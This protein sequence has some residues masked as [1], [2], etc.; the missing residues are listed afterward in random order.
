[1]ITGAGITTITSPNTNVAVG[2]SLSFGSNNNNGQS[3]YNNGNSFNNGGSIT[4]TVQTSV[5]SFRNGDGFNPLV[6]STLDQASNGKRNV[7]SG[8]G[9]IRPGQTTS[10]TLNDI[11]NFRGGEKLV[12]Q[13]SRG[14]V[15]LQ[16]EISEN[17]DG[18]IT[19][20]KD[21]NRDTVASKGHW[22]CLAEGDRIVGDNRSRL[23]VFN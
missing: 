13:E 6:Q 4:G 16:S 19:K 1:M 9:Q 12:L 8:S 14:Q 21:N 2:S 20:G 5:D 3:S 10:I 23:I 22:C 15:S 11:N 7:F 18:S 17:N